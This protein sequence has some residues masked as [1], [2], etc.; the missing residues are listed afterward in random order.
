MS[1]QTD[2]SIQL[3]VFIPTFNEEKNLRPLLPWIKHTLE[4][5]GIRGRIH[6][7][8]ATND[9]ATRK[10][11]ERHGV[12]FIPQPKKGF[13]EALR[14]IWSTAS[15]PY[16][17]T[18]DADLSHPPD[19]ISLLWKSR[20]AADVV[21][22][23]RY[24]KGGGAKTSKLRILLSRFLNWMSRSV[25]QTNIRD[26]TSNF[27]LYRTSVLKGIKTKRVR[28]D[29]LQEC[30]VQLLNAGHT[31]TEVP[32][33]YEPRFAGSSNVRLWS[34]GRD[35]LKAVFK[36]WRARNST[37]SVDYDLRAFDSIIPLQRYWQR[38]RHK[39]ILG[40]NDQS[41]KILDLGCGSSRIII[42][43]P[44]WYGMDINFGKLNFLRRRTNDRLALASV[45]QVPVKSAS[46]DC[47]ICSQVIEHITDMDDFWKEFNRVLKPDGTLIL[48]TPDYGLPWWPMFEYFHGKVLPES[49]M[50]E[51]CTHWT[52]K[53]LIERMEKE[54][55]ECTGYKYILGAELI[56]RGRKKKSTSQDA[57]RATS[58]TESTTYE[59]SLSSSLA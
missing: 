6:V 39:L 23:S 33:Y 45:S 2:N 1:S 25:L 14:I 48:G 53:T 37:D 47:V 56:V 20:D 21:I 8:D 41:G 5:S 31:I 24:V 59:T 38:K 27:R 17:L 35:Y 50:K 13:G 3:D 18:M 9:E 51:H 40:L 32:F 26:L 22:A 46:V 43:N 55:F 11:C 16:L 54:G 10:L 36:D 52:R 28:F 12:M 4:E 29:V 7:V 49:Y 44:D 30:L 42:D 58:R 19:F 15:A 34:F 57:S